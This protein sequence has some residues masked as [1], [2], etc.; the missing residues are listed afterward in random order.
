MPARYGTQNRI[1]QT[2]HEHQKLLLK[3]PVKLASKILGLA[4]LQ[5]KPAQQKASH[6]Q[7]QQ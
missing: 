5:C 7:W 2:H 6:A 4:L 1:Q 3:K